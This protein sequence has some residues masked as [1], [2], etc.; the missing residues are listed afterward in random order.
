LISSPALSVMDAVARQ[1]EKEVAVEV[2]AVAF[3]VNVAVIVCSI[4]YYS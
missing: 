2:T 4:W 1:V 3:G